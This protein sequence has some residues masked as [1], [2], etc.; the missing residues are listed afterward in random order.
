[1]DIMGA[2]NSWC[3]GPGFGQG[4]GYG[5]SSWMPFHFSGI[6]QLLIIGA[7]IYF[8]VRMF[9]KPA[10]SS[11][12]DSPSDILKRRYAAGEIDKQTYR[13]MKEELQDKR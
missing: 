4:S 3:S 8:T 11:G 1:M 9:R 13:T 10:T 5:M 12:P 2:F 7:I 6:F